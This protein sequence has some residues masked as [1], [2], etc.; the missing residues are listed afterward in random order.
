ME[1]EGRQRTTAGAMK[2]VIDNGCPYEWA[3]FNLPAELVARPAVLSPFARR[4]LRARQARDG[5]EAGDRA[6]ARPGLRLLLSPGLSLTGLPK[7]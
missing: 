6:G 7:P 1:M 2:T 4:A 5:A 3:E